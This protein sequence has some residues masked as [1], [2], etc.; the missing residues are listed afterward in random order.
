MA[1]WTQKSANDGLLGQNF[2]SAES[3]ALQSLVRCSDVMNM[4]L[5]VQEIVPFLTLAMNQ[6]DF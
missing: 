4:R 5:T 1:L 6:K 3:I 2:H